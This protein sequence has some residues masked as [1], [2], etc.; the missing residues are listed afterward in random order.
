MFNRLANLIITSSVMGCLAVAAV[1]LR[2]WAKKLRRMKMGADDALIIIGLVR[3]FLA[4]LE[5]RLLLT[6][7][8]SWRSVCVFATLSEQRNF[9]G[10]IMRLMSS[11]VQ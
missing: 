2:L 9:D 5:P 6:I 8:R 7:A 1:A 11:L 3:R 10:Y 4:Q